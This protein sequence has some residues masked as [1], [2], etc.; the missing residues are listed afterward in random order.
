MMDSMCATL[1]VTIHIPS[2]H[3]LLNGSISTF[4]INFDFSACACDDRL[5][6]CDDS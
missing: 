2:V 6:L 1:N 5:L 3:E 4:L